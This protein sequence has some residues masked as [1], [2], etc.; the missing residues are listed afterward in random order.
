MAVSLLQP[1]SGNA[2]PVANGLR[3]VAANPTNPFGPAS[4]MGTSVIGTD[5]T[6]LGQ[7]I[8]IISQNRLQIDGDV[9]G[10]VLG[11]EVNISPDGS[12]IGTISAER[13]DVHGGVK[14]AIRAATVVLHP[15]A[16]VDAEIVHKT[17]TISE[18]AEVE[19]SLRKSKDEREL[20]PNLDPNAQGARS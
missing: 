11:R 16:Q 5:L 10:D 3:P 14:G 8:S 19:G 13:I 4:A 17:L 1:Q 20:V 9:R 2:A 18:G 7:N 6:I 15:S 12:V